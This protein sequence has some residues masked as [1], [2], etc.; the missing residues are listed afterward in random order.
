M[1]KTQSLVVLVLGLT[2]L[3]SPA[4]AQQRTMT[5]EE[6]ARQQAEQDRR[7][8]EELKAPR[9]IE[10]VQ[11]VWLEELTWMEIRDAKIG[12]AHV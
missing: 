5:P 4:A 3:A 11:S 1:S 2:A 9:P 12:R 6:R 10:A 7:L 8:Q